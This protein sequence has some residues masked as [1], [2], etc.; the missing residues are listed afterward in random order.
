MKKALLLILCLCL[1]FCFAACTSEAPV[2]PEQNPADTQTPVEPEA[3]VNEIAG[4]IN[5]E[6]VG[7]TVE[8]LTTEDFE[9]MEMVEKDITKINKKGEEKTVNLK[10]VVASDLLA[11]ISEGYTKV[12]VVAADGYEVVCD[13]AWLEAD[14]TLFAICEGG[15]EL[16]AEELIT[17]APG[18]Q[19]GANWVKGVAKIVIE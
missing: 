19:A 6:V 14:T 12:T 16:P 10:G 8:A 9:A 18:G 13:P 1:V 11:A 17:F 7:G 5:I 15:V 4:T 2:E 3:P